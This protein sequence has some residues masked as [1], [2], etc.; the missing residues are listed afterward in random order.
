VGTFALNDQ[1]PHSEG[2]IV[3][4]T[5]SKTVSHPVQDLALLGTRLVLGVVLVAH[6][7]QKLD[8][9]IGATASGFDQMGIPGPTAAAWFA[10]SV[11]LGGGVLL[12]AGLATRLV[13]VLVVANM[14]GAFWF[15]HRG[16]EVFASE[17]GWE[18][19]AVIAAASLGLV[20]AGAGRLSLDA[21]F[22]RAT[23][24]ALTPDARSTEDARA[25]DG[26]LSGR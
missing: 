4:R 20:A 7:W 21:W 14:A 12:L 22:T 5:L 25:R 16:T 13:G 8:Q 6:G 10:T 3:K 18:L 11:E 2:S 23:G 17:G 1:L 26:V 24:V 19:V 9:G 15:A